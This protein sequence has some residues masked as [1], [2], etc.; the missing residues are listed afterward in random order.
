MCCLFA[1]NA[2]LSLT[3]KILC[4]PAIQIA[5]FRKNRAIF[6]QS[7]MDAMDGQM[8]GGSSSKLVPQSMIANVMAVC[9]DVDP[10]D[11]AKDLVITGSTT[12]TINRILDGQVS[13]TFFHL[14]ALDSDRCNQ[15]ARKLQKSS[16]AFA[17]NLLIPGSRYWPVYQIYSTS[18]Y[19]SQGHQVN[20]TF[21]YLFIYLFILL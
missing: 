2:L 7:K 15:D 18:D 3:P 5:V 12:R 14:F 9:P 1:L 6:A 17:E 10:K 4:K 21:F 19:T 16:T 13:K 11:V 8:F 20:T